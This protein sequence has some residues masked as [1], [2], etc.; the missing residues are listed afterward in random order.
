MKK[1]YKNITNIDIDKTKTQLVNFIRNT[2]HDAGFGRV[3][4]GASGGVDSATVAYLSEE[5]LGADNVIAAILP[6]DDIDP[7][8]ARLANAVI[9]KLK[10]KKYV[11]DITPMVD[12]YFKNFPEADNIRRGNKMARERMTILYDLSKKENAL[13]IG[14]GNK[15]ESL[16]GYCTL[17]GDTACALNPLA[18]LYKTQIYA[19][20]KYLGVPEE[21]IKK[22]PT[23]GLWKGQTDEG[24]MGCAYSDVDRLLPLM[25]DAKLT[26][27]E[28][29]KEGFDKKFI[30]SIRKRIKASEFKRK[31]PEVPRPLGSG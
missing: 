2:V 12:A 1:P 5:A 24:E 26:D 16:L 30:D 3:V 31:L 25:V 22:K 11:V 9:D 14:S 18:N 7:D 20:A 4:L 13:V 21:I 28:L 15:T 27:S 17:Y 29:E 6:Y 8:G 23:A 19:L 10:I